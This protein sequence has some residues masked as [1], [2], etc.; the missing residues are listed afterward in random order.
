MHNL[1]TTFCQAAIIVN[2]GLFWLG[3]SYNRSDIAFLSIIN[4][5]LL[6]THFIF[7]GDKKE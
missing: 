2:L 1:I 4:V 6:S 7:K 5:A 3:L